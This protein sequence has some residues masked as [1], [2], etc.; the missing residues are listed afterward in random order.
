MP[1]PRPHPHQLSA[2]QHIQNHGQNRT[3]TEK[4][5]ENT[6]ATSSSSLLLRGCFPPGWAVRWVLFGGTND[7]S[8]LYSFYSRA[9]GR[10]GLK[11][12]GS[13][14]TTPKPSVQV[15]IRTDPFGIPI[16]T[17]L[18][19]ANPAPQASFPSESARRGCLFRSP[20]PVAN[21]AKGQLLLL[22]VPGAPPPPAPGGAPVA[23]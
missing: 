11:Q 13:N 22:L 6:A 3:Y 2:S 17:Y 16:P 23:L 14:T 20:P 10:P 5:T 18:L 7:D 12:V 1:L 21:K 8:A 19:R 9:D 4:H 15:A